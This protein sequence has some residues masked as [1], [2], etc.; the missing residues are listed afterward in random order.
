MTDRVMLDLPMAHSADWHARRRTGIGGSDAPA[1]MGL[2][3]WATP[4]RIWAEKAGEPVE[5]VETTEE[6][7]WGTIM[8]PLVLR[9]YAEVTGCDVRPASF[10]RH[11]EIE[12]MIGN[13][14]ATTETGIVE[15][16]TARTAQGWGEPGTDEI[17]EPYLIQVHHYLIVSGAQACDVAVLIGGSDFRIYTV[18][19]DEAIHKEL[20]RAESL[21]WQRVR[22]REPP[23]P[24]S[25]TDAQARWGRIKSAGEVAAGGKEIAAWAMACEAHEKIKL[26]QGLLE[27]SK[28]V[29][30]NA[31]ADRGDTLIGPEGK[32]ICTWKLDR[33]TKGYTVEPREPARKMLIKERKE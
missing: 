4:Y 32:P 30:A 7:R 19:P 26:Y 28:L 14:D 10:A 23:D 24:V 8:E 3:P 29:L 9:R 31:L 20:I 13:F 5:P 1:V 17:P 11:P 12:W 27:G 25:I 21:F 6:M 2:S 16:K 18:E 22:D 33:G 15:A